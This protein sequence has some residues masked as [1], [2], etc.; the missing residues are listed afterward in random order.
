MGKKLGFCDIEMRDKESN[1][2]LARG[3]HI[4]YLQMGRLWDVLASPG[5]LHRVVKAYHFYHQVMRKVKEITSS[6]SSSSS[7][8]DGGSSSSVIS[9]SNISSQEGSVGTVYHALEL[10][11]LH[12]MQNPADI[13]KHPTKNTTTNND[14]STETSTGEDKKQE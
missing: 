11:P 12:L 6:S 8:D 5:M 9:G 10:H 7:S 3:R 2:L 14:T 1:E 4:K 13:D